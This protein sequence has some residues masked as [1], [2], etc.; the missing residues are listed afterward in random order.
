MT[1]RSFV[2]TAG[3]AA[4]QTGAM[5][6][7]QF[8]VAK[9][10]YTVRKFR[11]TMEMLEHC[12]GLGAAGIQAPLSSTDADFLK[13][14]RSRAEAAGMYV[15]VQGPLPKTAD[16]QGLA[17]LLKAAREVGARCIRTVNPGPR[18]Y[19]R[20]SSLDEWRR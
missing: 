13:R 3:A 5:R 19:E 12:R 18:R 1:R 8:G 2:M 17:T 14:L 6:R 20:F 9:D 7:S 10:S 11:D 16:M 4:A 15:E